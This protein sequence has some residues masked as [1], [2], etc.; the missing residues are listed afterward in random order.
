M[1]MQLSLRDLLW[2]VALVAMGCGWW[3]DR[4]ALSKYAKEQAHKYSGIKS[5]FESRGAKVTEK[6]DGSVFVSLK[7]FN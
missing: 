4:G 6:P 1:K 7:D 3:M 5:Y 2:L